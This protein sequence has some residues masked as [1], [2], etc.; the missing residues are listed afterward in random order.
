[1]IL[2]VGRLRDLGDRRALFAPEQFQDDFLL[3]ACACFDAAS[4]VALAGFAA[5]VLFGALLPLPSS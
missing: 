5:L 1:V 3:T 2:P 4:F